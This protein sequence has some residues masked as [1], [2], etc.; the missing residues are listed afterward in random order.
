[1]ALK[2]SAVIE[3]TD[4]KTGKKEIVK[5]DNLVTNAVN[6]ILSENPLEYMYRAAYSV[7]DNLLPVI[8][9]MIGGILL[10]EKPIEENANQYYVGKENKCTGYSNNSVNSGAD[11]KRGSI[12][13]TESGYLEDGSGYRFVFDFA[14]SQGN[15]K[16]SALCMT[17]RN[18]G[19]CYQGSMQVSEPRVMVI[20]TDSTGIGSY[21]NASENMM[22]FGS[23][24]AL[25]IENSIMLSAWISNANEI[26]VAKIK[27]KNKSIG[28]MDT[29]KIQESDVLEISKI[30]TTIFGSTTST[31]KYYTF[32]DGGD[33]FIWGFH[34]AGNA[35]GNSSGNANVVWVK[36]NKDDFSVEEGTWTVGATILKF[37]YHDTRDIENPQISN[38]AV[39]SDGY[40]YCIKYNKKA[41]Y[42]IEIR[43]PSNV[44]ELLAPDGGTIEASPVHSYHISGS[45]YGY[46]N[47]GTAF[48]V[49]G[50][51]IVF[52]NG[53]IENDEVV[54]CTN[55]VSSTS[56]DN[57]QKGI[58]NCGKPGLKYGPFLLAFYT[59][60]TAA[61]RSILLPTA[62]LATINNLDKPVQ[63]TADKTMKITYILREEA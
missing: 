16:I 41:I 9:K 34:H 33:G 14:T 57:W 52:E 58:V 7:S 27:L 50:N 32:V 40:L 61:S 56:Y 15:G 11:T 47:V 59:V 1:M 48:N 29:F 28:L 31:S 51:T 5:H 24:V 3:L 13:I 37:G 49:F 19:M 8:P 4:V 63:K 55:T 26:S 30:S 21:A 38:F 35:N 44:K 45:S 54:L 10:F 12:N 46:R 6:D 39:I 20:S 23:V 36:I 18:A 17:S 22:A 42:K 43:N 53:F 60:G 62:Y 2:G 25:D